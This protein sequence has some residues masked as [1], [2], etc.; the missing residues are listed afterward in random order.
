MYIDVINILKEIAFEINP[1]GTF[2]H[3]RV[4]DANLY[5]EKK[6]MPQVHLYPFTIQPNGDSFAVD[7]IPEI[8]IA[9]VFQDSPHTSDEDRN[10]IINEADIMQ[11]RLRTWLNEKGLVYSNYRAQPYFKEFNGVTSGMFVRF[12][13]TM[14]AD[15]CNDR[16]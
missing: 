13:L 6:P 1:R 16:Y 3:G 8:L 9:L 4:S 2:Y 5:I 14:K 15:S 10:E 12:S 11:R 7:V